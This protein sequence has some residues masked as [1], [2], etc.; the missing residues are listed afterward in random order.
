[1]I[2]DLENGPDFGKEFIEE[3][4]TPECRRIADELEKNVYI[5]PVRL[6]GIKRKILQLY[7]DSAYFIQQA[8]TLRRWAAISIELNSLELELPGDSK[9]NGDICTVVRTSGPDAELGHLPNQKI[10]RWI[11]YPQNKFSTHNNYMLSLENRILEVE[12][13]KGDSWDPSIASSPKGHV[14]GKF[15]FPLDELDRK[16]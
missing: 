8:M 16:W 2:S 1:M 3:V 9:E 10:N 5:H 15:D 4:L 14:L 6:G 11:R 12:I 7:I 13:A